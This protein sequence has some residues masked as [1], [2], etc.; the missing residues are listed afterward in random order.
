MALS[1]EVALRYPTQ[2]LKELTNPRTPSASSVDSTKLAQAC[3]SVQR[4]FRT[5]AQMDYDST[6][7]EHVDVAVDGVVALLQRWGG[8]SRSIARIKWTDWI[9]E[10]RA[11]RDTGPRARFRPTSSGNL[12]KTAERPNEKAAFDSAR[13]EDVVPGG[14]S[15]LDDLD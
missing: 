5:Y 3:T 15:P 11:L 4:Q 13:F 10:C 2:I 1:D 7:V 6:L 8:S 12:T 14:E 9:E